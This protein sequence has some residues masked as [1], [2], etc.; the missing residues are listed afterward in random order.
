MINSVRF[1]PVYIIG[2]AFL[3]TLVPLYCAAMDQK[4]PLTEQDTKIN[5]QDQVLN[6]FEQTHAKINAQVKQNVLP[7][8]AGVKAN[9]LQ[10]SLKK[11]LIQSE[12]RLQILKLDALHQ[13]G[14]KQKNAIDEMMALSAER[15]RTKMNYLERLKALMEE[16]NTG[17]NPV[18]PSET[19]HQSETGT[20][21]ADENKSDIK[22]KTKTL[23]VEIEIDL[24][25]IS[26]GDHD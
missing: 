20:K 6:A 12:A 10:I 25:D 17:D 22:W 16:S 13:K 9:E 11:Y 19:A 24:E 15:E 18:P 1:K 4:S 21:K 14:D 5:E 7:L 2:M 3:L 23:D 26:K 8:K